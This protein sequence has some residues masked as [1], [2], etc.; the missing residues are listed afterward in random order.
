MTDT[1]I[2][3]VRQVDVYDLVKE[4]GLKE[5][6]MLRGEKAPSPHAE[7]VAKVLATAICCECDS[8]WPVFVRELRKIIEENGAKWDD[9]GK[10][11]EQ[12]IARN[13]E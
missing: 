7:R 6:M 9:Q 8:V 3:I 2:E 12:G 10:L 4:I 13:M 1:T 11:D 5:T